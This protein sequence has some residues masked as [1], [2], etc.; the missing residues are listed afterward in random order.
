MAN[1]VWLAGERDLDEVTALIAAFRDWWGKDVPADE[2][3]QATV[4]TLLADRM[5][6]YLLA[7][8]APGEPA[9]GVCQLR[10]RLSVWTGTEDCWME[11]LYVLG[12]ARRGGIGRS[13]VA[14]ALDR[15][16][17]RGC[18]RIELDVNEQNTAALEFYRALGFTTEPKPPGRTLFVARSLDP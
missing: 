6:E 15:A 3:I 12:D 5:T 10:Y 9:S 17:A 11:D 4:R 14:A 13:L 2:S 7:A 16:R 1:H 8:P 18:R